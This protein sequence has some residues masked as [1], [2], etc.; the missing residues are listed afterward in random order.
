MVPRRLFLALTIALSVTVIVAGVAVVV[1][2]RRHDA[3]GLPPIRVSG[4]PAAVT[5]SEANLMALSPVPNRPA[6]AFSLTD[7]YG[8]VI[9]LASLRGRPVVLNFMDP[10]CVDICPLVAQELRDAEADLTP[11]ARNT[12]FLAINVNPYAHTTANVLAF[13]RTHLLTTIP[14]W[15]FLTGPVASL[16]RVWH[17]YGIEVRAPSPTADVI[18]T[19]ATYFIDA[20]GH[21][22]YLASPV[23]D[24]NAAGVAFLPADTLRAWGRGIAAVAESLAKPS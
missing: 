12:V 21:E 24:H 10:H 4:L 2:T 5:T 9:S 19:A 17:A 14:T 13:S 8:H 1:L 3:S 22:R 16:A 20:A 11:R 7:Q 15:H 23:V 6:P 18:H